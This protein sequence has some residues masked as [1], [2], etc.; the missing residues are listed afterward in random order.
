MKRAL[1]LASAYNGVSV[2]DE[3]KNVLVYH[4]PV[5]KMDL[6]NC[7]IDCLEAEKAGQPFIIKSGDD[8]YEVHGGGLV[9]A[10]SILQAMWERG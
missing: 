6:L 8:L 1:L 2:I 9:N 4:D 7:A 10:L 5:A 3:G